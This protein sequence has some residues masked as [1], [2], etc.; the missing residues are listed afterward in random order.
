MQINSE[1]TPVVTGDPYYDL[2]MGGYIKPEK[3]VS[4]KDAKTVRDAMDVIAE[5]FTVLEDNGLIEE[6]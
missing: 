2:F 3:L 6:V 1:A 4:E 5:F